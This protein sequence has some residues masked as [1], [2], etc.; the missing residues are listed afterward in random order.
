MFIATQD[1]RYTVVM[2]QFQVKA[3]GKYVAGSGVFSYYAVAVHQYLFPE[4]IQILPDLET[5]S[6]LKSSK[7]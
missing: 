1:T 7:L 4:Y 6:W 3:G 2:P 5:P